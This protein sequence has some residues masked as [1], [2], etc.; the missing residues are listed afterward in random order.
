MIKK[1]VLILKVSLL[2]II[3]IACMKDEKIKVEYFVEGY[4]EYSYTLEYEENEI[5]SLPNLENKLD[6]HH[7]L[8]W[9]LEN[10]EEV[11]ENIKATENIKLYAKLLKKTFYTNPLY[12]KS[13]GDPHII[14]HEDAFYIFAT[15]VGILKS[16]DLINWEEVGHVFK[17][18]P[19]WGSPNANVW[20][21][22]IVKIN[23]KYVLYYSLSVWGDENPG[24]GVAVAD[25]P[26]GPW[27]DNG[28]LFTSKEIG[29]NNSIDAGVFVSEEGKVYMFWGSF[30]GLYAVELE[31]DG[32]S[33]K[34][35]IDYANENKILIAGYETSDIHYASTYEGVYVKYINGYYYMFV[36]SGNCCE[37]LN[38]SY[39]VRVA[40]SKNPLGPYKDSNDRDML[41]ENRG[42]QVIKSSA[43]MVGPGHNSIIK[44]DFNNYWL[45]YH[46]FKNE[47]GDTKGRQLAIDKLIFDE[48]GWPSVL[49]EMPTYRKQEGPVIIK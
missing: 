20:A 43:M 24:I 29:V 9:S 18:T 21:P 25:H 5:I 4:D 27:I 48:E 8:N 34:G 40:R 26:E 49:N 2:A 44:D 37:G 17:E 1:I 30:K 14:R 10:G 46:A 47:D 33:L 28:K 32:L 13:L 45:V 19:K 31:S 42:H 41:G 38:S 39:N 6:D 11:D 3:L 12:D 7:F 35:G 16:Y 22:D 23:N 15:S 36:S